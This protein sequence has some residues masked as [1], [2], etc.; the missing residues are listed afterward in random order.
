MKSVIGHHQHDTIGEGL[1]YRSQPL[2]P[3]NQVPLPKVNDTKCRE[4]V[5]QVMLKG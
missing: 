3:L 5:V 4:C 1:V 2:P